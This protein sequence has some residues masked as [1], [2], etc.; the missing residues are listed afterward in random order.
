MNGGSFN[1]RQD[2]SCLIVIISMI[3]AVWLARNLAN[4]DPP[5]S[6]RRLVAINKQAYDR[7]NSLALLKPCHDISHKPAFMEWIRA[8]QSILPSIL[9][10]DALVSRLVHSEQD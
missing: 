4:L 8:M 2:T 1:C 6:H 5:L 3:A 9:P 10:L 7:V